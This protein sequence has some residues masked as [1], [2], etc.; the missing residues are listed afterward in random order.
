MSMLKQMIKT[1]HD[2]HR[3]DKIHN[4]L[5]RGIK[6]NRYCAIIDAIKLKINITN[7]KDVSKC[8]LLEYNI[9]LKEI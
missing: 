1:I 2:T 3:I 4:Q 5:F 7:Q 8:L 6:T 9:I